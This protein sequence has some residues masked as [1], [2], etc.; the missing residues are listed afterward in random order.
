MPVF[1]GP[2]A[3]LYT[4]GS[5]RN[6]FCSIY[7]TLRALKALHSADVIHRDLKPS[8]L[9]LNSNCDLKGTFL[10]LIFLDNLGSCTRKSLWLWPSSLFTYSRWVSLLVWKPFDPF[11]PLQLSRGGNQFYDRIRCNKM[12]PSSASAIHCTSSISANH[13]IQRDNAHFQAIYQGDRYLEL[14]DNFG[15]DAFFT[16]AFSGSRLSQSTATDPRCSWYSN[17]VSRFSDDTWYTLTGYLRSLTSF[18]W[19]AVWPRKLRLITYL[20]SEH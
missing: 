4:D 17:C 16:T 15:W 8:N 10:T 19:A 13:C 11:K 6:C 20:L 12:V 1:V 3:S 18:M 2:P 5:K 7:Q 14:R 9:L